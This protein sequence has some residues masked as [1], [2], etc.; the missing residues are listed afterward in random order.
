VETLISPSRSRKDRDRVRAQR[1]KAIERGLP[2]VFFVPHAK[3]ASTTIGGFFSSGFGLPTVVYSLIGERVIAPWLS[4]YMR[5]GACYVTHLRAQPINAGLLAAGGAPNV[6]VHVRDP[7][8]LIV[9]SVEHHRK[10]PDQIPEKRRALYTGDMDRVFRRQIEVELPRI[11]SWITDWISARA[12]LKIDFTSYEDFVNA[13]AAFIERIVGL[14]GG[15]PAYFDR[16]AA[17]TE[18]LG[19]DYHR[20]LGSTDEWRTRLSKEQIDLIN[21]GIPTQLWQTFNW[22]E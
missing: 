9:S 1:E 17:T 22:V 2:S 18:H 10:Y 5:G 19:I 7:R 21:R 6:I 4:E 12:K 15:N 13:P 8:Q 14:Y 20:R 3:T 16:Q 11:V